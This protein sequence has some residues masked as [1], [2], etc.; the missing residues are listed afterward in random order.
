MAPPV[1]SVSTAIGTVLFRAWNV[2]SEKAMQLSA[3]ARQKYEEGSTVIPLINSL[4]SRCSYVLPG[5]FTP[6]P[7]KSVTSIIDFMIKETIKQTSF[8]KEIQLL[9]VLEIMRSRQYGEGYRIFRRSF[10][11]KTLE[12]RLQI[13]EDR[14]VAKAEFHPHLES[15]AKGLGD[16]AE[17]TSQRVDIILRPFFDDFFR[18]S[19]EFHDPK[20]FIHKAE[21]V[22][23][24]LMTDPIKRRYQNHLCTIIESSIR[25]LALSDRAMRYLGMGLY[26]AGLDKMLNKT[27]Q[28]VRMVSVHAA[29]VELSKTH[30]IEIDKEI[31][32]VKVTQGRNYL[33]PI[34][35]EGECVKDDYIGITCEILAII[36]QPM[37]ANR[38]PHVTYI[39]EL[40]DDLL[41]ETGILSMPIF[42]IC[43]SGAPL[44]SVNLFDLAYE[45]VHE[46]DSI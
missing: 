10:L 38:K 3:I 30:S 11:A 14:K 37:R 46:F 13:I 20:S 8:D 9:P 6:Y 26:R 28:A 31:R 32:K 29:I 35:Q 41:Q 12:W 22:L 40:A 24:K 4:A 44:G 7:F 17:S 16:I 1:S 18:H 36:Q 33:T 42:N 2:S 45:V 39:E 43:S 21:L 25:T 27:L 34:L 5:L 19:K 15:L 23:G